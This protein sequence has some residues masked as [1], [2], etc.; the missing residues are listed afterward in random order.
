MGER[1]TSIIIG[2]TIVI[3]VGLIAAWLFRSPGSSAVAAQSEVTDKIEIA[4]YI[5]LSHV[6]IATSENYFGQRV[7][8]IGGNLKNVSDRPI[9]TVALKMVFSDFDGKPIMESVQNGYSEPMKPL[10]PGD[11]YR[12]QVGFDT[13]PR[14]WNY[15]EPTVEIVKVAY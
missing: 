5:Q 14:T 11:Q 3:F 4:R 10:K 9:R 15:H 8:V 2:A 12:F 6:G 13:L 7:R 1:R